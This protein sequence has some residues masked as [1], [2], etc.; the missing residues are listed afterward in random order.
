MFLHF[1]I[2][3]L[4]NKYNKYNFY[5]EM[6]DQFTCTVRTAYTPLW[7]CILVLEAGSYLSK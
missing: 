2:T 7:G 5:K 6:S 1:C 3:E 4:E